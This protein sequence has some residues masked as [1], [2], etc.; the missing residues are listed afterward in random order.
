MVYIGSQQPSLY[1]VHVA[2]G[3]LSND[4]SAC[5]VMFSYEIEIE[6]SNNALIM[7]EKSQ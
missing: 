3:M 4:E 5:F 7:N 2:R 6:F 1:I